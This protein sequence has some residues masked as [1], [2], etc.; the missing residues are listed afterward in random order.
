MSERIK[1]LAKVSW[2]VEDIQPLRPHWSPERCEQFLRK[3]EDD[4]QEAMT[5]AGWEVIY[6]MLKKEEHDSEFGED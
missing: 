3:I 6:E 1:L 2:Q 4:V 5:E